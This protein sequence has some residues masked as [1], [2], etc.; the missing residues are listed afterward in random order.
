MQII[1]FFFNYIFA[2]ISVHLGIFYR[3]KFFDKPTIF[4]FI[5][6]F[7]IFMKIR[8]VLEIFIFDIDSRRFS[9]RA[10]AGLILLS[11]YFLALKTLHFSIKLFY[12]YRKNIKLSKYKIY[13]GIS[14]STWVVVLTTKK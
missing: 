10:V 7:Y 11:T 6:Y 1:I 8:L 14:T 12:L 13:P 5:V 3:K 9:I 2:L 4:L